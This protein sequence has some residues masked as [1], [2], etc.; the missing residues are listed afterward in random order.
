MLCIGI[1]FDGIRQNGLLI[2]PPIGYNVLWVRIP[3]DKYES[4]RLSQYNTTGTDYYDLNEIYS[5]GLRF[6]NNISPD[7]G[8]PGILN[9]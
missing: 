9:P 3:S 6:L 2:N 1:G 5:G 8:G 4:F 7:G